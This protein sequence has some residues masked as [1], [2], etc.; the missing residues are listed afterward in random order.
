[1]LGGL[2]PPKQK[3]RRA[4]ASCHRLPMSPRKHTC[5]MSALHI[6]RSLPLQDPFRADLLETTTQARQATI[7]LARVFQRVRCK[8]RNWSNKMDVRP[9]PPRVAILHGF[10]M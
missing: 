7:Q 10:Q 4:P 9:W 8:T 2:D 1:M 3:K 6:S 5:G